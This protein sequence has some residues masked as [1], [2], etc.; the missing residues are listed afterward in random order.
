M[1]IRIYGFLLIL[2]C[3]LVGCCCA[4]DY[5]VGDMIEIPIGYLPDGCSYEVANAREVYFALDSAASTTILAPIDFDHRY[6]GSRTERLMIHRVRAIR[7]GKTTIHY[8]RV[9]VLGDCGCHD[10]AEYLGTYRTRNNEGEMVE[11][12]VMDDSMIAS[13]KE[14]CEGEVFKQTLKHY[15]SV[16]ITVLP[17]E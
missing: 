10:A 15:K 1:N 14:K 4:E 5:H 12:P 2:S 9:P 11:L 17:V 13:C 3:F 7:P 8:N 16:T 6:N